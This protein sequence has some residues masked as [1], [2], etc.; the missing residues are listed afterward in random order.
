[1]LMDI[2]N[3]NCDNLDF[4]YVVA[5]C[6]TQHRVSSCPKDH[7]YLNIDLKLIKSNKLRE[8]VLIFFVEKRL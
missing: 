7:Q 8:K 4:K 6:K 5:E 2:L 1:M 3:E